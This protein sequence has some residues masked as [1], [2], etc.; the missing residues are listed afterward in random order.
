M[1]VQECGQSG[2]TNHRIGFEVRST[3]VMSG[4][5]VKLNG[6]FLFPFCGLF[7]FVDSLR[8][9]K[10]VHFDVILATESTFRAFSII[11]LFLKIDE[12]CHFDVMTHLNLLNH[13]EQPILKLPPKLSMKLSSSSVLQFHRISNY[14]RKATSQRRSRK[15]HVEKE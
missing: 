5:S 1:T 13:K 9:S 11:S 12:I 3:K 7:E 2:I 10:V 15:F 6:L 14:S 8:N 4:E